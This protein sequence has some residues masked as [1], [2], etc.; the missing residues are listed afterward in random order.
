LLV[1]ALS[2]VDGSLGGTGV[3]KTKCWSGKK[4]ITD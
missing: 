2:K 1:R 4:M 3:N